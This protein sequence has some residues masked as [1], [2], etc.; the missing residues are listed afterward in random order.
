MATMDRRLSV[1]AGLIGCD[2]RITV[3]G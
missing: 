2:R 3:V 1:K